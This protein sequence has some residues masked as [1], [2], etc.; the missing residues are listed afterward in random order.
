MVNRLDKADWEMERMF[1]Q[2]RYMIPGTSDR[3]G[4]YIKTYIYCLINSWIVPAVL[5]L[6]CKGILLIWD[7]IDYYSI[8]VDIDPAIYRN[9]F[10]I[11][12][13]NL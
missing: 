8:I 5:L 10:T 11:L 2:D 9:Q 6:G 1:G 4:F 12:K 13:K 3:P 7:K